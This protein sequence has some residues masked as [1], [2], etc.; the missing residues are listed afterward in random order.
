MPLVAFALSELWDLRDSKE[1]VLPRTA[2]ESLGGMAGALERHA[3]QTVSAI[4]ADKGQGALEIVRRVLVALTTARGTRAR[5][6]AADL[7]KEGA[8]ARAAAVLA[9]L[10][11]A[12]LVVKEDDAFAL[13]HEALLGHW[14]RLRHWLEEVRDARALAAEIEEAAELWAPH[15]ERD[16][17]WRGRPLGRARDLVASRAA[18]LGDRARAFL[19][20]SR[21][22]DLRA[23]FA[24][25][26]LLAAFVG[27]ALTMYGSYRAAEAKTLEERRNA[28]GFYNELTAM[29]ESPEVERARSIA[30][31]RRDKTLC[32]KDLEHL[33]SV[34]PDA[35]TICLDWDAG[36]LCR[37]E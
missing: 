3:E 25:G 34:S 20:T 7:V 22:A 16:R 35:G 15:K 19:A 32:E 29:R 28:M 21:R 5:R 14:R 27:G 6:T 1:R 18:P 10:E 12:R 36:A 17:L 4:V 2:L 33:R 11:R 26:A 30:K 31:L 23:K 24:L 13:A 9:A 8:D 37:P